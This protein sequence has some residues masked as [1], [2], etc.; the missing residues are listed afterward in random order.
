MVKLK[1]KLYCI[2]TD[3]STNEIQNLSLGFILK[4]FLKFRKFQPPYSYKIYSY[5]KK[6][7]IEVVIGEC[8]V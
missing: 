8:I 3:V 2:Y 6:G 5:R 1:T 4:I 7:C